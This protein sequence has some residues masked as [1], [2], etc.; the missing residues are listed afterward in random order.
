MMGVGE[1]LLVGPGRM[2]IEYS[3]VLARTNRKYTVI[4]RG[5]SSAERFFLETGIMPAKGGVENYLSNCD[6]VAESAIVA[7]NTT[8]LYQ[9]CLMLLNAGIKNILLE[10]PGAL[11]IGELENLHDISVKSGA[12]VFIAYN[13][14]FLP[15]VTEARKIL[16]DDGGATSVHFEFTEWSEKVEVFKAHPLEKERWFLS[17]SSH[18]ADLAFFLAGKPA[19]LNSYVSGS[20]D[21]HPAS[22]VFSGSGE[23]ITG[24]LISYNANWD[25][26]GRWGV[27]VMSKN[28]RIILRPLEEL[29]IQRRGSVA[30]EKQTLDTTADN[31][32]KP[33]LLAMTAEFLAGKPQSLCTLSDHID[34]CT[35][36]LRIAGYK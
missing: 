22:K 25:A 27:E 13:R 14:R 17:N 9:T 4:G 16:N 18:V 20:L 36:Y 21:W 19:T 3:K 11:Y 26:P 15:S 8:E 33:G 1:L 29:T 34:N 30:L 31:G 23:T 24:A 28:Y 2:G 7:V 12:D 5:E 35:H 6:V 32:L 10:K